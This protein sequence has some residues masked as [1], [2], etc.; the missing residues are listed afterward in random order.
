MFGNDRTQIRRYFFDVW[1]KK[2]QGQLL[3]GLDEI[4]AHVIE[5]HP[6]YHHYLQDSDDALDREWLPEQGESN[7]FLQDAAMD[8][9]QTNKHVAIAVTMVNKMRTTRIS[10]YHKT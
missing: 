10:K 8:R 5:I 7:P 9:D 6:E 1:A 3:T 4:I 2:N